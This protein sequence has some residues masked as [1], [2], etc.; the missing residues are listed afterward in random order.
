MEEKTLKQKFNDKFIY[1]WL[2]VLLLFFSGLYLSG[3]DFQEH[4][5]YTT[6][7]NRVDGWCNN[8]KPMRN[9][10]DH[11]NV[12]FCFT[13]GWDKYKPIWEKRCAKETDEICISYN[14]NE[15]EKRG[16][17]DNLLLIP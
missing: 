1:I 13:D 6:H 16:E 14:L 5:I 15:L 3:Y 7:E 9:Y 10:S 4:N 12:E 8:N 17:R 2:G 11:P